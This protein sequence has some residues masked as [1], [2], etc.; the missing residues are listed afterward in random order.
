[1]LKL[2]GQRVNLGRFAKI[3]RLVSRQ[4]QS[5]STTNHYRMENIMGALIHE[6]R[7]SASISARIQ[8]GGRNHTVILI[9]RISY[10][11]FITR[12]KVVN[13]VTESM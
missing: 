9:G 4:M 6:S 10:K 8:S 13:E 3:E 11:E 12:Y 1:M 7:L 5:T 2:H